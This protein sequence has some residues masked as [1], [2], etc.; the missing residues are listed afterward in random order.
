MKSTLSE[1]A[2][3]LLDR[4]RELHDEWKDRIGN[5]TELSDECLLTIALRDSIAYMKIVLDK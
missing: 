4:Y 2:K 3:S 1:D 5:N